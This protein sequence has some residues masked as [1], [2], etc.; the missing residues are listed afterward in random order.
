M[1][2]YDKTLPYVFGPFVPQSS[3]PSVNAGDAITKSKYGTAVGGRGT[4]G[5]I[6]RTRGPSAGAHVLTCAH[7]L[8]TK[9]SE[10]VVNQVY[11]PAF[12]DVSGCECNKPFGRVVPET[13][14]A[15]PDTAIQAFQVFGGL[16]FAVDA[17]LIKL[18]PEAQARNEIPKIG[19]IASPPRNLVKEWLLDSVPPPPLALSETMQILVKKYGRATE[20]TEGNIRSIVPQRVVDYSS[21]VANETDG[22]VLEVQPSASGALFKEEYKLDMGRFASSVEGITKVKEVLALFSGSNLTASPGGS[23][24]APTLKLTGHVFSQPGDSGSPV[25]DKDNRIVGILAGG[26]SKTIFVIDKLEPVVIHCGN[27]QVIFISAALE[28]LQVDMLPEGQHTSGAPVI[29]PGHAIALD[30][31]VSVDWAAFDAARLAIESSEHGGQLASVFRRHFEEVRS[32]VHHRRRVMVTWQ[33]VKGSG[34]LAANAR[35]S[36]LPGWPLTN[37]ID[38]VSLVEALRALRNVLLAEGSPGLQAAILE[39]EDN[40]FELARAESINGAVA[41]LSG[42]ARFSQ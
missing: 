34:F 28:K 32:L 18:E 5:L 38:G 15:S 26:T 39:H 31:R 17:A 40:I 11:S 37:E 12:S 20:Y 7:V 4:A 23:A 3:K 29:V 21:G 30:H 1:G 24:A 10:D 14:Q 13:Q 27:S 33:R 9:T 22:L 25:V 19:R 8:G 6:V 42:E 41:R 16:R 2:T 36:Q 35:A